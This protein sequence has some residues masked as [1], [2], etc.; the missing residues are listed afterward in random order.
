MTDDY[1]K[2][3]GV[4]KE[5]LE[6]LPRNNAKNNKVY[7]EKVIELK[8]QYD[9]D[10]MLLSEEIIKRK[11]EYMNA[12]PDK[13]IDEITIL[14]KDIYNKLLIG[15]CFNSSY[16]NSGLDKLLYRLGHF[17]TDTHEDINKNILA[18][19][20]I[21]KLVGVSINSDDFCYS[22]YSNLYMK[23]LLSVIS[24]DNRDD[25]LK[26]CFDELYW[27]CPDII[28][29]ITLN[30]KY[31]YYINKKMFDEYYNNILSE[32]I[33]GNFRNNYSELFI[34]RENC[35]FNSK[36]L[37]MNDFINN[38]L[39][40]NDYSSDRIKKAYGYILNGTP[41]DDI[42]ED[43]IN[44]SYS[45]IEYKN[46]LRFKYIIDDI[47]NLYKEKDKYKGVYNSKKKE[48]S[49]LEK[50][51][52]K[53]N[54]KI[55]KL[56]N[57]N[58][59]DKFNFYNSVVNEDI[60][61]LKTL[62]DELQDNYFLERVSSL[63]GDSTLYDV[64]YLAASNYNYLN[65]L[66]KK[67]NIDSKN[68]YNDLCEFVFYPHINILSNILINDERDIA[69]IIIDRYNLFGFD[70]NNDLLGKDNLDNIIDN[71]NIIINS[72]YMNKL[73]INDSRIKFIKA[74]INMNLQ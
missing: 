72:I 66:M 63:N 27:K 14:M 44:L 52:F 45:L 73:G 25:I 9:N 29:H 71:V 37:Y 46:Y 22:Y 64:L 24:D 68:E 8:E 65:L 50:K 31:L 56:A 32:V 34:E 67:N 60:N 16:E 74:A 38:K 21:F 36:Y 62:Y 41:N 5:V 6:A 48:I 49:K 28:S 12:L 39:D 1:N 58:K 69:T 3:I 59:M 40:I 47:K 17:Y 43:V 10:L 15:N 55:F 13:K 51:I 20:D 2:K 53:Q 42:N 23:K 18:I 4:Q 54:R 33:N 57:G 70:L 61:K 30:F 26:D 11:N 19:L 35:I 7:K